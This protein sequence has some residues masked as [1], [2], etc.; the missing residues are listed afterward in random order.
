MVD[1]KKNPTSL[2][3]GLQA[4]CVEE[5]GAAVVVDLV[6]VEDLVE[7]EAVSGEFTAF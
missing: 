3:V 7:V 2:P 5:E 6:A 4:V 1:P